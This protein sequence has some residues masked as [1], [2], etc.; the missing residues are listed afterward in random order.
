[1]VGAQ[2][3]GVMDVDGVWEGEKIEKEG[4]CLDFVFSP[5][6]LCLPFLLLV[7]REIEGAKAHPFPPGEYRP[8]TWFH[9]TFSHLAEAL[10]Q[11]DLQ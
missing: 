3:D 5:L 1:M 4:E 8:H 10:I 6:S 11:S 2:V 7:E 9:F